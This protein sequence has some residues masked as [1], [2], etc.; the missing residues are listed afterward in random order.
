[1]I[2]A[3]R[4][5][6]CALR[7]RVDSA[8]LKSRSKFQFRAHQIPATRSARAGAAVDA[9]SPILRRKWLL[10]NPDSQVGAPGSQRAASTC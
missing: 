9:L 8:Q 1:M 3:V 10:D 6:G 5:V 2:R 4:F 7:V